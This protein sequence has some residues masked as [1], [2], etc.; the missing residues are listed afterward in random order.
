MSQLKIS[1]CQKS[2]NQK[3]TRTHIRARP[4]EDSNMQPFLRGPYSAALPVAVK[5]EQYC[6][7]DRSNKMLNWPIISEV[8]NSNYGRHIEW[9]SEVQ[10]TNHQCMTVQDSCP[11]LPSQPEHRA[12]YLPARSS[13]N[14]LEHLPK[15]KR[16]NKAE[17]TN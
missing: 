5:H 4:V 12:K 16:C 13:Q 15:R 7:N 17:S 9:S 1:F 11:C 6:R 3:Q 14:Q 10:K 8:T 2:K